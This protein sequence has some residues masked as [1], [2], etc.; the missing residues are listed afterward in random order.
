M[1]ANYLLEPSGT[2][3]GFVKKKSFSMPLRRTVLKVAPKKCF[4]FLTSMN[5]TILN[6]KS[7][8]FPVILLRISKGVNRN[9]TSNIGEC[10][11]R[12]LLTNY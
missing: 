10:I 4:E 11:D 12:K 2:R 1:T 9:R 7:I 8:V 6:L 3:E 5:F